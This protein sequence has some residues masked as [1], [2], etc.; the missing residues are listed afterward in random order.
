MGLAS[1]ET[2]IY[3]GTE[4]GKWG[5]KGTRNYFWPAEEGENFL[6]HVSIFKMLRF[7]WRGQIWVKNMK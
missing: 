3:F 6:P 7:L 4:V 2:D 1:G 5:A